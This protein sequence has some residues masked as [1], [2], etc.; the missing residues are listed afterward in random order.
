MDLGTAITLSSVVVM[1]GIALMRFFGQNKK[2]CSNNS[3][4][5]Y[6]KQKD[7]KE[8]VPRK[9][10][11]E[12]FKSKLKNVVYGDTCDANI[13]GFEKLLGA[14]QKS[15]E[16]QLDLVKDHLSGQIDSVLT[17]IKNNRV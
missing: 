1:T 14:N 16:R 10:M 4:G 17:E 3:K 5:D 12:A 7:I 2:G 11:F 15:F 13:K 9:E 8:L 6:V